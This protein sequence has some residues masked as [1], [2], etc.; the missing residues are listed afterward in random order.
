LDGAFSEDQPYQP[1]SP[2]SASKAAGDH[3]VR[4]WHHTFG[5]PVVIT[6]C[7]NNYGPFQFPEKLIPLTILNALE[8][9]ALPVYGKGS[10]IRDWLFVDDHVNALMRVAEDGRIGETYNIGGRSERSN[11]AVVRAICAILDDLRPDP[12]FGAR[13]QLIEFVTD[14]PGHDFRYAIDSKKITHDLGWAPKVGFET[15]LKRTV[16]WYLDN[17]AW[18]ERVRSGVYC[19]ERLGIVA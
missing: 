8:G 10:N 17:R 14:R 18:W 12:D 6:N 5:L 4:A 11:L 1:R 7:S 9:R 13:A 19:G 15:G 2:Y 3:L 16:R